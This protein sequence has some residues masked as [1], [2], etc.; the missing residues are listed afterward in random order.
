M[1]SCLYKES[2]KSIPKI[3]NINP[4]Y[5]LKNNIQLNSILGAK[6]YS[7]FDR[8]KP[9]FNIGTIGHVDH[10]KT[11][12][13]AAITKTLYDR[14][15]PN[16]KFVPYDQ[17]DKAPEEKKR[18][19][20][21]AASHVE[22]ETE[23]R[24]YSHVDCPGHKEFVKNMIC[25][26]SQLDGGI[27][28]VA[29][30]AGVMPQTIEH[31][32]LAKQVGV[33][34]LVVFLNKCDQI[35]DEEMLELV[36]MDVQ[37]LLDKY[38]FDSSQVPIVRGSALKALQEQ[39]EEIGQKAIDKLIETVDNELSEPN[40]K[41]DLPFLMPIEDAF[42]ISGRGTVAT[43]SVKQGVLNVGDEVEL[44]GLHPDN[45]TT[46]TTCT[47]IE[48]F[49]KTLDRGEAGDN[50]GA[51][52]RGI[53]RADVKRGQVLAKPGTANSYKKFKAEV[54]VLSEEEGGRKKGFRTGYK[55]Q[56][57]FNTADIS[58]RVTLP[59]DLPISLPGDHI[60]GMEVEL[61]VPVSMSKGMNFSVREGGRTVASGIISE[62]I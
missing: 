56:F 30:P 8:S 32:L 6:F 37:E 42:S 19:I 16:T 25:G 62:L 38:G 7:N 39:D 12:L 14:G 53:E 41:L 9:H 15:M 49:K 34:N 1:L 46:K 5:A 61:I 59:E 50:L 44:V 2:I 22:Y 11:T 35:D 23:K 51:L 18:G 60:K 10:G 28:V 52:L 20:T 31:I 54:Y 4:N 29:A 57:F 33:P 40:R 58:G 17:I 45:K 48:M 26:A 36:E 47:G 43:G 13:T 55:P 24:H 27:L 3:F 21:I